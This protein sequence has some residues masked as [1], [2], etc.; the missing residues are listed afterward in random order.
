MPSH[1]GTGR[2]QKDLNNVNLASFIWIAFSC[3]GLYHAI[4][5]LKKAKGAYIDARAYKG[6]DARGILYQAKLNQ[7]LAYMLLAKHVIYLSLGIYSLFLIPGERFP[8]LVVQG[9]LILGNLLAV[10]LTRR[11]DKGWQELTTIVAG[12]RASDKEKK[13]AA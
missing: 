6:D 7:S 10:L 3:A 12:R 13:D 1:V 5:I 2:E 11:L 9:T 8:I 4:S